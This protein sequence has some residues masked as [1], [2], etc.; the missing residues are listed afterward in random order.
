MADDV[1]GPVLGG[2]LF[3]V[4]VAAPDVLA[5]RDEWDRLRRSPS[6]DVGSSIDQRL[7]G[8]LDQ[9]RAEGRGLPALHQRHIEHKRA[10]GTLDESDPLHRVNLRM[11]ER[12]IGTWGQAVFAY[13]ARR[14]RVQRA[15]DDVGLVE[16]GLLTEVSTVADPA[17]PGNLR[18]WHDDFS[19][20]DVDNLL[21]LILTASYIV[22]AALSGMRFSEM[23]E[24]RKGCVRPEELDNGKVRHRVHSQLI[25]GR[26]FGGE[27]ERWTVV[28]EV[29]QAFGVAERLFSD[30]LPFARRSFTG[31]FP[32]FVRWV[33]GPGSRAFLA[34]IP[35]HQP[36]S[37]RQFRRTLARLV[38]FRPHGVLAGKI[39]LKHVSVATSEGYYG[40]PG[41]SAAAFLAEVERERATARV[42]ATTELYAGWV[43]GEQATGPGKSELQSLF[44]AV[45]AEMA[46]FEGTVVESEQ[47]VVELLR[48]RA[49]TLH[50]GPL[51]HCWF[52]DPARARCLAQA[53]RAGESAPLIGM[54][55]PTRCANAT[56][57]PVHVPVWIDTERRV[58]RLLASSRVPAQEKERLVAERNRVHAVVAAAGKAAT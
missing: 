32:K 51:N 28:E 35:E 54:C 18:P 20:W 23:A 27:P 17:D 29:A 41:S 43:A 30:E 5:A 15:L 25:K 8:Y 57:H 48:R 49:A 7:D 2:A 13:P 10:R 16:G 52:V 33:N 12:H 56:I 40:R 45:H 21:H 11:V 24:M 9:L 42:E 58:D 53:G 50:V 38:G 31:R 22:V 6:I 4:R 55:E 3:L 36:L 44:A 46:S 1:F 34:P 26:D 39:H 47:R 19:P 37:T 14:A